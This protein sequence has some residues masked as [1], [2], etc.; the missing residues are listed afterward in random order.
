MPS[1][2]CYAIERALDE[3]HVWCQMD[4][5][6]YWHVRRN[7]K[8]KLWK[9]RPDDFKIPVKAGLRECG[10]IDYHNVDQFVV[11]SFDP[12]TGA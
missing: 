12:N 3:H 8:T 6:R 9:T 5:G 2:K 10:Y 11:S 7:G 1:P 4:N